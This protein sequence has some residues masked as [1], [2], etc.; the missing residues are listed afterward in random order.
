MKN[1][2]KTQIATAAG[3]AL[4]LVLAIA[5]VSSTGSLYQGFLIPSDNGS[6]QLHSSFVMPV[7]TL[8]TPSNQLRPGLNSVL[9]AK[10]TSLSATQLSKLKVRFDFTDLAFSN[11]SVVVNG[12]NRTND[13]TADNQVQ[14]SASVDDAQGKNKT[15]VFEFA[16]PVA[17]EAGQNTVEVVLTA[18]ALTI[19]SILASSL[20]DMVVTD[21]GQA[22]VVEG[23]MEKAVLKV[24]YT[25]AN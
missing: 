9:K 23:P 5:A 11:I 24:N 13:L 25:T 15:F 3:S 10:I 8:L 18:D 4:V 22:Y 16:K 2:S 6:Q 19:N 20:I 17:L 14:M 7:A 21:N 1:L 12:N